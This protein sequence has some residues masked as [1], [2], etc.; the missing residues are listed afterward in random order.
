MLTVKELYE[1]CKEEIENGKGDNYV[2]LCVNDNEF[3]P[4]EHSFSSPVYND[5]AV[6]NFLEEEGISEDDVSVLN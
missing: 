5:T 6:Y 1:L 3:H 2:V 4:L